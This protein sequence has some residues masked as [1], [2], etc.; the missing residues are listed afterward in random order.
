MEIKSDRNEGRG[1]QSEEREKEGHMSVDQR[2]EHAKSKYRKVKS[3]EF[4]I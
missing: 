1:K 4:K 3:W 2:R